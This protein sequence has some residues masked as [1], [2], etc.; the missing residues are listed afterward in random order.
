MQLPGVLLLAACSNDF[1][2]SISCLLLCLACCCLLPCLPGSCLL[3]LEACLLSFSL[4]CSFCL[5]V[6]LFFLLPLASACL[7]GCYSC[8]LL[9]SSL[10]SR[11]C[12]CSLFF[13][14][15][16]ACSCLLLL[17]STC[18]PLA[19]CNVFSDALPVLQV[20]SADICIQQV[21]IVTNFRKSF[22]N[23]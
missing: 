13:L 5:H 21:V 14:S 22:R 16:A 6:L 4:P 12:S 18:L 2:S 3:L 1:I 11:A 10:F 15:S 20:G 19:A 8:T 23:D 17:A 9:S 7:L